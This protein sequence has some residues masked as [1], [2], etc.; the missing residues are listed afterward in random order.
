[1]RVFLTTMPCQP[2]TWVS[3]AG[4]PA[5]STAMGTMVAM[6]E[7]DNRAG[8]GKARKMLCQKEPPGRGGGAKCHSA[9]QALSTVLPLQRFPGI[10]QGHQWPS[11]GHQS[12]NSG[13]SMIPLP[14]GWA[15]LAAP[16]RRVAQSPCLNPLTAATPPSAWKFLSTF[17]SFLIST[18]FCH[19]DERTGLKR[20]PGRGGV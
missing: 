3:H 12:R 1:M 16:P 14:P 7:S 19:W 17:F 13:G 20:E 10:L 2:R 5:G 9:A 11:Q 6:G 18:L 8:Y 15:G 4:S